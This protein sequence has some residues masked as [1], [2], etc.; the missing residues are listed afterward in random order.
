LTPLGK[1]DTQDYA[2]AS[3]ATN[4]VSSTAV[5]FNLSK[6]FNQLDI[7]RVVSGYTFVTKYDRC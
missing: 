3:G 4:S 2:F 7:C 1:R 5:S 6:P